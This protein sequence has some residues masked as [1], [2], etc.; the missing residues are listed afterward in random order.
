MSNIISPSSLSLSRCPGISVYSF[1]PLNWHSFFFFLA[2]YIINIYITFLKFNFILKKIDQNK[3]CKPNTKCMS[4]FFKIKYG[5]MG[6]FSEKKKV[7]GCSPFFNLFIQG[8]K[9][10]SYAMRVGEWLTLEIR[11]SPMGLCQGNC[12]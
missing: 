6:L 12:S 3:L 10:I 4:R 1:I 5:T 8:L 11:I 2:Q 7:W 9:S